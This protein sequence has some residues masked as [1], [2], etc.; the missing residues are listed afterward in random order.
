LVAFVQ[1]EFGLLLGRLRDKEDC[2][3]V[4]VRFRAPLQPQNRAVLRNFQMQ[5]AIQAS[6]SRSELVRAFA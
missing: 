6:G 3:G 2:P 1:L 5:V 4:F